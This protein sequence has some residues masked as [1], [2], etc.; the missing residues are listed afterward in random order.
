MNISELARHLKTEPQT[1]KE[2]LPELGIDIGEKAIQ[3]DDSLV[4]KAKLAWKQ[5]QKREKLRQKLAK[6]KQEK[7]KTELQDKSLIKLPKAITVSEFA[8]RIGIDV[9][10]VI[11]KLIQE[12]VMASMNQ[13]I[14][15]ETASIVAEDF[16]VQT[17]LTEEESIEESD[18]NTLKQILD[19]E[20]AYLQPRPPIVVVMGH[21]DHGKTTL[22]DAIRKTNIAE[23]EPGAITQHI[24]AYQVKLET[25]NEYKGKIITFIDTPGHEAFKGMRSRGGKVADIAVLVIAADDKIQPQTIESI[26]IIQKERL[27]M[28]VAINKID[29]KTA[30]VDKIKKELS[31]INLTPEDWSGDVICVPVSAKNGE[32][33]NT[34]L[35]NILLVADIEDLKANP[36][37]ELYA[38]IIESNIDKG[39]GPVATAIIQNGT[40]KIGDIIVC[41]ESGGKVKGLLDF[42][43]NRIEYAGPSTPVK[44]LGFKSTPPIGTIISR[45]KSIKEIKK[46]KKTP[47]INIQGTHPKPKEEQAKYV[48]KIFLKTD[49]VGTLEALINEILKIKHEKAEIQIIKHGLGEFNENDILEAES[50]KAI[51]ISFKAGA[52]SKAKQLI[53]SRGITYRE[54]DVIYKLIEDLTEHLEDILPPKVTEE[55]IGEA[56]ILAVFTKTPKYMIVGGRATKGKIVNNSKFRIFRQGEVMGEG[57]VLELQSGKQPKKQVK[58]PQEF[59]IKIKGDPIIKEGDTLQ[60]Y[61]IKEEKIKLKK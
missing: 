20:K 40:L 45:A 32:N 14:D 26:E 27:A 56:E 17:M 58:A 39:L 49:V 8:K 59:G 31:E 12:G 10:K 55:D 1:L 19:K 23:K 18:N 36:N 51:L 38:T 43:G 53:S 7:E 2:K 4:E 15:Y 30:D 61:T 34:L 3:I 21:V 5:Y 41:E 60:F 25:E 16:G 54:Y 9:S 48:I 47:I 33:I 22:L 28:I 29:S 52:T 42:K 50:E 24:G 11:L 46:I 6:R 44:I 35:E 13:K 57:S 37:G